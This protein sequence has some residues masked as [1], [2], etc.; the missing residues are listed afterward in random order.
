MRGNR[1]A[2]SEL[3]SVYPKQLIASIPPLLRLCQRGERDVCSGVLV[4]YP[5]NHGPYYC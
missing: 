1:L 3:Q 4:S 2:A 5:M